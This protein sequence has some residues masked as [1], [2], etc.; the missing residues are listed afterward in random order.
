MLVQ[1][2]TYSPQ[3]NEKKIYLTEQEGEEFIKTMQNALDPVFES[4]IQGKEAI[5]TKYASYHAELAK[6]RQIC[7]QNIKELSKKERELAHER[8][9]IERSL[10]EGEQRLNILSQKEK[11]LDQTIEMAEQK[12]LAAVQKRQNAEQ[13]IELA[14][15]KIRLAD[16]KIEKGLQKLEE[17][18][19]KKRVMIVKAFCSIFNLKLDPT[20]EKANALFIKH[21]KDRTDII[22]ERTGPR[23]KNPNIVIDFLEE[24]KGIKVCNLSAFRAQ[25]ENIEIL[26][27]YIASE[28][29]SIELVAVKNIP[30]SMQD[31]FNKTVAARAGKL[32]IRFLA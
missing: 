7:Q 15:Q 8:I 3:A 30:Q 31:I 27:N 9:E 6:E 21:L 24:H 17:I 28:K 16:Q 23:L 10:L 5:R 2:C 13:R 18:A 1:P 14:D 20:G 32:E 12:R 29:C 4:Y 11:A 26:T 25:M 19:E 22:L